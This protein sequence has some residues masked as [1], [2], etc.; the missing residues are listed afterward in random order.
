MS[1]APNLHQLVR[2]FAH[3]GRLDAIFL[4]PARREPVV[5]VQQVEA[6]VDRGLM[7]DRA[8]EKTP[9]RTG[10]N[11]RQVTLIQAEH[12]PVV[13]AFTQKSHVDPAWLRRNLVVSGLN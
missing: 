5:Q 3:P 4:R 13:A 12:M 8:A 11:K 6:L 1:Q 2:Q 7:G 9:W 10:G